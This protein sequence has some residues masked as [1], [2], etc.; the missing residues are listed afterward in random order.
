MKLTMNCR[1]CDI[2][3]TADNE[4]ELVTSVQAHVRT[5]PGMPELA[6]DHILGRL[7]RLQAK[8]AEQPS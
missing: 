1:R 2:T 8:Q 4:D 5:H 7:H 6:P 3:I